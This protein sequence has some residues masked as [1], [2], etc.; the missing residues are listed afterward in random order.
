[1]WKNIL[2]WK[3]DVP[4][5]AQHLKIKSTGLCVEK[6][7]SIIIQI[8]NIVKVSSQSKQ[9]AAPAKPA[10]NCWKANLPCIMG[11]TCVGG[12]IVYQGAV[13]RHDTGKKDYYAGFSEARWKPG[14]GNH[15]QMDSRENRTAT[16]LSKP[17]C[18]LEIRERDTPSTSNS[19]LKQNHS[20]Q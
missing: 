8:F 4:W 16:C 12:N 17:I 2:E 15:K 7:A 20:A 1:M 11:E 19:W 9:P 18:M 13:T 3:K 5:V 14:W 10:C 6:Q